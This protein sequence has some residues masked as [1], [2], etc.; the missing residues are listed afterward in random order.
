[1]LDITFEPIP[2]E[3]FLPNF[4]PDFVEEP[5]VFE[6]NLLDNKKKVFS[7]PALFDI[8]PDDTYSFKIEKASLNKFV[9]IQELA[10]NEQI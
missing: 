7:L 4:Q 1:M 10:V 3:E 8:N 5:E 9:T 6:I 2:V